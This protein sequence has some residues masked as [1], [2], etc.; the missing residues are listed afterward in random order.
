M[1]LSQ[2]GAQI[3]QCE[4]LLGQSSLRTLSMS[5]KLPLLWHL[6][7]YRVSFKNLGKHCKVPSPVGFVLQSFLRSGC[8][9]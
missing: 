8:S 4:C 6:L 7:P 9:L 3:A 2:A 5:F 1:C